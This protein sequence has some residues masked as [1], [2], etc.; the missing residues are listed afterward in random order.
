MIQDS[1]L[2]HFL[3]ARPGPYRAK[4]FSGPPGPTSSLFES[5]PARPTGLL[6]LPGPARFGQTQNVTIIHIFLLQKAFCTIE[7]KNQSTDLSEHCK[8]FI[9][10]VIRN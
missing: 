8:N 7:L 6:C 2:G 5:G 10:T 1:K 4:N 3:V 9:I